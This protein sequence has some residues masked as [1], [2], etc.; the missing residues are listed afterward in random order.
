MS[1][2]AITARLNEAAEA[3]TPVTI[4]YRDPGR[5]PATHRVLPIAATARV[6]RARDLASNEVKLFLL[7]QLEITAEVGEQQP[8]VAVVPAPEASPRRPAR[9]ILAST[10]PELERLGWHVA[11]L[12]DRLAV[13]MTYPDGK[14]MRA[15]SASIVHN[16]HANDPGPRGRRR[17]WS[18]IGPGLPKARAFSTLEQAVA[19]FMDQAR[20]HAPVHRARRSPRRPL[21]PPPLS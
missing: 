8:A 15:V 11:L 2:S 7:S 10:A 1:P 12:D 6:L 13:H 18:V 20:A 21:M 9:E 16:R 19:V 14:P 17:P 4:V 5:P 3:G